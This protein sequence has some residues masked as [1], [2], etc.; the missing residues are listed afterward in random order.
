M[1]VRLIAEGEFEIVALMTGDD[2]PAEQF[3]LN[4]PPD[5]EA[6]REGL[7]EMLQHVADR[8][9]QGVPSKWVHEANKKLQV[10]EF[11]KGPLRLFFF[12]GQGRQIAVCGGGLRK[13][14]NKA[15]VGAVAATANMRTAYFLAVEHHTLEVVYEE[16]Q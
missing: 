2:C 5:T 11:I 3:L 10:Y 7:A 8:G 9:F 14:G 16:D 13:T 15:D 12:K 4:G 1:K 6:S